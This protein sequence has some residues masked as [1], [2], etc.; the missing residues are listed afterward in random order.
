MTAAELHAQPPFDHE[1]ELVLRLV[2]VPDE[3]A[4]EL[5]SLT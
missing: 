4:P 1:K 5:T 3:L 2:V